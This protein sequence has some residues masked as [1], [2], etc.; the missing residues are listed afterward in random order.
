MVLNILLIKT[1]LDGLAKVHIWPCHSHVLAQLTSLLEKVHFSGHCFVRR[2]WMERKL[3]WLRM[4][5]FVILI[6][7]I[8]VLCSQMPLII[9][10]FATK[11]S[12]GFSFLQTFYSQQYYNRFDRELLLV[13]ETHVS[14][15]SMLL[16]AEIY[17][18]SHIK[19]VILIPIQINVSI[20]VSFY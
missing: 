2:H 5:S 8:H 17:I 7:I 11:C 15:F 18:R 1:I 13:V 10:Y 20:M 16:G 3:S 19:I 6:I 12:C 14:V 9:C 4:F